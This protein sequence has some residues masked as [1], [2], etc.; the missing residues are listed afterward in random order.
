MEKKIIVRK[1][2]YF[3]SVTLM[4][5]SNQIA[6]ENGIEEAV[7]VMG[8]DMNKDILH[9]VGMADEETD[10]AGV[11]D[12]IIAIKANNVDS[13]EIAVKK[14]DECLD[15][16]DISPKGSGE[17]IYHSIRQAAS[18]QPDTNMA[19]ISVPGIYAAREARVA[20][21]N[22]MHVMLFSDNV[23]IEEEQGLKEL[24]IRK[25]RLMMGPDCGTA[26]LD[27]IGL[28][29]ANTL[30]RGTI[31]VI[32]ASGTGLQEVLVQ[33]HQRG[34]GISQAIGTGGRDLSREIGGLMMLEG[35][36][37]LNEDEDTKVIVLVSKPPH[38]V[39]EEKIHHALGT[40]D[41]PV[42]LCFLEG[43]HWAHSRENIYVCDT[44]VE[45]A[46]TAIAV[47]NG[48]APGKY[49]LNPE[50]NLV[51]TLKGHL[52]KERRYVRGL[53][54]GGTLCAESLMILRQMLPEIRSNISHRDKERITGADAWTGNVLIDL[55]E[56][57]FTNGKPHPMLEPAMRN[58]Y[59][60]EQL[61]DTEVGV[62]LLDVELGWGAHPDPAQFIC[63]ILER[64][65]SDVVIIGYLLGTDED[66][67]EYLDQKR[68]LEEAGVLLMPSNAMAAVLAGKI[69]DGEI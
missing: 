65:S 34:G 48:E 7:V 4:S 35:I 59:I 5:I 27:G 37:F 13:V 56:D 61:D 31:G 33:I 12:L 41:K 15:K 11:N 64:K 20:L 46:Y 67:Q 23:S 1:N 36:R 43:A 66:H 9:K 51:R 22:G 45:T 21:E 29:F 2:S 28:C 32:G 19:V 44:L 50:E 14:V 39:V 8:T 60:L 49:E 30:R 58:Q 16:K 24:A 52:N 62:I 38:P 42:V 63:D 53:F 40:V 3:D 68:K 55:G 6:S 57:E 25:N 69:L 26:V 17:K 54:C 10:H 18:A 47:S